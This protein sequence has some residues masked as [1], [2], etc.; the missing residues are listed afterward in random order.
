MGDGGRVIVYIGVGGGKYDEVVLIMA[1]YNQLL[2]TLT[3]INERFMYI[4][5]NRQS[6]CVSVNVCQSFNL[7][8]VRL[9]LISICVSVCQ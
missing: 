7:L 8:S 2:H 5:T 6:A 4:Y 1:F 3:D 9:S